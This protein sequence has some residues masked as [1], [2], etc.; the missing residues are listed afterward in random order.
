MSKAIDEILEKIEALEQK[1]EHELQKEKLD[2]KI[3]GKRV[4]FDKELIAEQR[5]YLE[6]LFSYLKET[7]FLF[8]LTAP[9]IYSLVIPALILDIFVAIYQSINFR[10]YKIAPV[11]RSDYIVIDRGS[12]KYLN[13]IEKI[14]CIYCGYFNGLIAYVLE[15]AARTEQYWCPIK[16]ARATAYKH[17]RYMRFLPYG[18]AKAFRSELAKL[19]EELARLK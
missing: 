6:N 18:D 5:E 4:K 1:L 13:I 8:Y 2:Y 3:V 16:H 15:V 12:L 17:S 19:R 7:K 10:V 9:I 14:N 11:K